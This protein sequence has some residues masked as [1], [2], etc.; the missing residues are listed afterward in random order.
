MAQKPMDLVWSED[1]SFSSSS[2]IL[3]DIQLTPN[4]SEHTGFGVYWVAVS[5]AIK[6]AVKGSSDADVDETSL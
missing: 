4:L 6:D 5:Y 1:S 2:L 3:L